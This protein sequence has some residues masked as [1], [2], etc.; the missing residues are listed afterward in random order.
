MEARSGGERDRGEREGEER[1]AREI[2]CKCFDF[3]QPF[4]LLD[5]SERGSRRILLF[6][7]SGLGHRPRRLR[8]IIP[9]SQPGLTLDRD[10]HY[11][12]MESLV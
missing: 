1:G 8:E 10:M 7:L 3:I 12:C 5:R 9:R 2:R 4:R 11:L 6:L